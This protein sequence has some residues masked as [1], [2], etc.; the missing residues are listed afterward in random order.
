MFIV[1][2]SFMRIELILLIRKSIDN[3]YRSLKTFKLI[4]LYILPYSMS[5]ILS[6][7]IGLNQDFVEGWTTI[8]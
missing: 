5:D 2:S 7:N 4:T 6:T 1:N 8:D 3:E